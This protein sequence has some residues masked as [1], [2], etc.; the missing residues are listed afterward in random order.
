MTEYLVEPIGAEFSNTALTELSKR[1]SGRAGQG[2]K[3][4]FV[5]Q[6]SQPGCLGIG[7]GSI[8]YVAVY[9]KEQ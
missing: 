8:T 7:Q 5:F 3:L 9:V 1:F 2:Y 6:V 4:Q